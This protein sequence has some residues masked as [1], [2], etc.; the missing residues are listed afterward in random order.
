MKIKLICAVALSGAIGKGNQLIWHIKKDLLHYKSY[1]TNKVL[2]IGSTTY[3]SLPMV[4]KR[5]RIYL[6]LSSKIDNICIN[7]ECDTPNVRG[8]KSVNEA[9]K[10]ANLTL[11][12]DEVIVVGGSK[13]Y[14]DSIDLVDECEI[15]W[16]LSSFD[17]ADKYFPIDKLN[18][19]NCVYKSPIY[20][21]ENNHSFMIMTYKKKV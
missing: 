2:I 18:N 11:M 17:D 21:E 1:T 3:D 9:I 8:F 6:V 14:S 4:A 13:I 12:V 16:V 7:L 20:T 10:Y 5:N 19:F 15:S